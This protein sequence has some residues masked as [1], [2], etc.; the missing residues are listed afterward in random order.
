MFKRI[1][2]L[3]L[4]VVFVMS[5]ITSFAENGFS[6]NPKAINQAAKSVLMLQVFDANDEMIATGSGF[7]AF[8]NRTIVTNYHV[9][10]E[11]DWMLANSDDGY[12]YIVTKVLTADEEKD[13]AICEFLSP[14]DL[15]PLEFNADG[16]LM[17]A[18]S[19]VA[20]GSPI[21]ITNTV[22]LGNISALY[23]EENVSWI[24]FTA[25]ISHGSSG[26]AL[27]DN[28]GNVI[29]VTSASYIDTQNLNLAV[30]ISEVETLYKSWNGVKL[31]FDEFMAIA[32]I[33][34]TAKPTPV[35]TVEPTP[36]SYVT[37]KRGDSGEIVY[38]LKA[39][40]SNL[41]YFRGALTSYFD[42]KLEDAVM[43]FNYQNF[44]MASKV[45]D[46]EMQRLLFDGTPEKFKPT[47]SPLPTA[48]PIPYK[49]LKKG[50]TGEE[51]RRLQEKL[52][53]LEYLTGSADGIFGEQTA[54]AV[55]AF[56]DQNYISIREYDAAYGNF[57]SGSIATN[58]LQQFLFSGKAPKY[59]DFD[60]S[61]EI[62]N[63]AYAEWYDLNGNMLKIHFQVT[64]QARKKTVK[65]FELYVYATDVWGNKIYGSKIYK[66]TTTKNVSPGKT[67][68]SDYI[69]IPNRN[70]INEVYCG[71]NKVAYTDGTVYTYPYVDYASWSIY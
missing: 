60:A 1:T 35:P 57:T 37:L 66:W 29:G 3:L 34:P 6:S 62:K 48:T 5:P 68:Y 46:E 26:G 39:E 51:V 65:A 16:E 19:I 43:A 7:V 8:N 15:Q 32:S 55:A 49:S 20:I 25:P 27:F 52:I 54:N 61:L 17:R 30:H 47:P 38:K 40:L 70:V 41:G 50:D 12:Q 21:G 2:A 24:Q 59:K 53:K 9:I 44:G 71:I 14:T 22:S 45:A 28:E 64:N 56:I 58:S 33:T 42:Y 36:T 69:T 31:N 18:E 11:A 67:T 4:M 63:G 10:E 23:E 13:I